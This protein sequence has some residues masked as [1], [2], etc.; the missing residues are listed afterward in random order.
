MTVR[1]KGIQLHLDR[2]SVL[3]YLVNNHHSSDEIWNV[4]GLVGCLILT[5]AWGG[6]LLWAAIQATRAIIA[7]AGQVTF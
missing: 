7:V 4:L 2:R 3:E 5:A 6:V 1:A